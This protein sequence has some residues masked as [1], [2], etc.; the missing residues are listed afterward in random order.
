LLVF[1]FSIRLFV[2]P[3]RSMITSFT[4]TKP[5]NTESH[6]SGGTSHILPKERKSLSFE[7]EKLT[8]M[9]LFFML[10]TFFFSLFVVFFSCDIYIH[11]FCVFC[12][13]NPS[14]LITVQTFLMEV[15]TKR[16]E[17]GLSLAR[18]RILICLG[19]ISG[20]EHRCLRNIQNTSSKC[21]KTTGTP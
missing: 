15:L 9:F 11:F 17:E 12:F 20:T 16:K 1:F 7:V 3:R 18:A 10:I 6:E 5:S 8:S 14:L 21:M 13:L 4:N 2:L 19:N